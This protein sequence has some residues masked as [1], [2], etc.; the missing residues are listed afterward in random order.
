MKGIIAVVFTL[1]IMFGFGVYMVVHKAQEIPYD[2]TVLTVDIDGKK[3]YR[4]GQYLE[5]QLVTI[6]EYGGAML[7]VHVDNLTEDDSGAYTTILA[8]QPETFGGAVVC[9]K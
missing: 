5:S 7:G 4:N 1:F 6:S 3:T 9:K 2:C 8:Y